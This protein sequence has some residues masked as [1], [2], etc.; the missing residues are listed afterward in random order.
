[1]IHKYLNVSYIV[2]TSALILFNQIRTLGIKVKSLLIIPQLYSLPPVQRH[3]YPYD[4][5]LY[6]YTI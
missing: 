4:F 6:H 3:T 5:G 2:L 1:M